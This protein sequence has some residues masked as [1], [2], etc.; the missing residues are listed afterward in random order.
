M[1]SRRKFL[2][3]SGAALGGTLFLN[4]TSVGAFVKEVNSF[5]FQVWTIRKE[6]VKDFNGTLKKM[7]A[8]GYNE[9]EMCSPLG[10]SNSGFE[11]LNRYSG[12]EMRKIIE[13]AG[14]ICTSSHY[15]MSELRNHLDN[16]IDWASGIGMKQMIV[17]SL[18]LPKEAS[19]D[20]YR[21][22]ADELNEIGAKTNKAGIQLGFHNHHIEFEKRGNDL[23]YDI[24]L[25]QFEPDLVKL[26]FQVAVIDLGYKAEDYFRKYPGRFIS[27]HLADY[28]RSAQKQV[29]I[30]QGM[31]NWKDFFDAAKEN[32]VKNFY[33]E[34][35]PE[36]FKPSADYLKFV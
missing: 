22:A 1:K 32:G 36:F 13:D 30:G 12:K 21:R 5:G 2:K 29:P 15:N 10:Y 11:P 9:V 7:A 8:M 35:E 24:L 18:G 17:A 4:K 33:V 27:A 26:Q 20:D 28:S 31:V 6:L 16:R 3:L 19:A 25:N 14:L 23:I 34:M